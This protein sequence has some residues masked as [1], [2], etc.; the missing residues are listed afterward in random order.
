MLTPSGTSFVYTM[1]ICAEHGLQLLIH[2]SVVVSV[3]RLTWRPWYYHQEL[4]KSLPQSNVIWRARMIKEY[5]LTFLPELK[6]DVC[7]AAVCVCV[8]IYLSES[9]SV[10]LSP[11][12]LSLSC[13]LN[14]TLPTCILSHLLILPGQ[15]AG[16]VLVAGE[17]RRCEAATHQLTIVQVDDLV[18]LHPEQTQCAVRSWRRG[19][20][21]MKTLRWLL[22]F[23]TG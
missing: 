15:F 6:Y 18:A 12:T 5:F 21:R 23:F 16:P 1:A 20:G 2:F 19:A 11:L 8:T 17:L 13:V 3:T 4:V 9:L 10:C 14:N 22:V 7:S